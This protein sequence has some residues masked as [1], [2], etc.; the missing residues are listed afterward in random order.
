MFIY[1]QKNAT[2]VAIQRRQLNK[3]SSQVG[4]PY[5]ISFIGESDV[6][7]TAEKNIMIMQA[8]PSKK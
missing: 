2:A 7:Q 8:T 3:T 4:F 5:M 1:P 6:K